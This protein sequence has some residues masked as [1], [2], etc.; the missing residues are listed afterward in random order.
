[1]SITISASSKGIPMRRL[2][3]IGLVILLGIALMTGVVWIQTDQTIASPG[4]RL[5][6]ELWRLFVCRCT[7]LGDPIHLM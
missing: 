1:M 6:D 4:L 5:M 2:L 3:L 7:M